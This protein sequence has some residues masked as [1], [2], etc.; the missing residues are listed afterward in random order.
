[1]YDTENRWIGRDVDADGDGQIDSQ[2]RFAYDGNQIVMQFDRAL[3]PTDE[4]ADPLTEEHLSHRY[5]WNPAA[6]DQL[7]ADEQVTDPDVAGDIVWPL[8]DHQGTIRDLAVYDPATDTTTVVNH[9]TFD[10][11]GNLQSQT[12]PAVDCLFAYTGRP[13][14]QA[15]GLQ[16]NLHRWYDAATGRWMSEDPIGFEGRDG[17]LYGYVGNGPTNMTDS[18]G[19]TVAFRRG[20]T[21]PQKL[22]FY[23]MLLLLG[24][25]GGAVGKALVV[26]I[27]TS[28]KQINVEFDPDA[29]PYATLYPR[30]PRKADLLLPATSRF[31]APLEKIKEAKREIEH[32]IEEFSDKYEGVTSE[33]PTNTAAMRAKV[34]AKREA[35]LQALYKETGPLYECNPDTAAA[36]VLGHELGHALIGLRD[37]WPVLPGATCGGVVTLVENPLRAALGV[38]PRTTYND[39]NI[40]VRRL[41]EI[42]D[43][44]SNPRAPEIAEFRTLYIKQTRLYLSDEQVN[45]VAKEYAEEYRLF[46]EWLDKSRELYVVVRQTIEDI[47]DPHPFSTMARDPNWFWETASR[48]EW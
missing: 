17:N 29:D 21:D 20:V 16:N 25:Y 45:V 3:A 19:T 46:T 13:L 48:P 11:Y 28:E 36:I 42:A 26:D 1:M 40:P 44:A 12:N 43:A 35:K 22:Y 2:T 9:R 32:K 15:T 39:F 7:M 4:P 14:D 24:D 41:Y 5:L 18:T 33:G 38:E 27:M 23:K 37:P 8:V 10:A 30:N 6:V 31:L 47:V 34:R